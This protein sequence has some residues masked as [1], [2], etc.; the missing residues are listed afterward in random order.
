MNIIINLI[1]IITNNLFVFFLFFI[2]RYK[3]IDK[4]LLLIKLEGIGDFIIF[5]PALMRYKIMFPEYKITLLV[6][7]KT[8]YQIAKRYEKEILDEIILLDSKK[9]SKSLFHRFFISKFLYKSNYDATIYQTYYRRKI[10]DFLVKIA[11][12]KEKI[13]FA[14]LSI[15][16]FKD[17]SSSNMYTKLIYIPKEIHNEFYRHKYFIE[18]ISNKKFDNFI[19]AFP[20]KESD[21]INAKELLSQY[22]I[23][24]NFVTIFPGAGRSVSKWPPEKFAKVIEYIMSK[25]I[26]IVILGSKTEETIIKKIMESVSPQKAK[27][28]IDLSGK[29]DIFITAGII[30]LSKFYFGNDSGPTHLSEAIGAMT[31]CPLGLGHFKEFYPSEDTEKTRVVNIKDMSCLNDQY[32]CAKGLGREDP[33]PCVKNISVEAVLEEINKII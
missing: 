6:D 16:R 7:N 15:E 31:I 20:I 1:R 18:K 30:K 11:K 28:V 17:F 5:I 27:D 4:K 32:A 14:G 19:T 23:D 9:F 24:N 26:K 33:A 12:S 22:K 8:N 13:S 10:G 3:N 21:I 2:P 25:S 29:T